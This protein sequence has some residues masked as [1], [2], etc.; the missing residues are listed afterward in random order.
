MRPSSSV[1]LV[2]EGNFSFAASLCDCVSS[3]TRIVATC[4]ESEEAA[5]R[6]ER[7]VGN[8][9]YLL[10]KGAEVYFLVDCTDLQGC[11][12]LRSRRFD[13]IIF[14][15]PHCGRK[16]GVKKNR[17][18]LAK[19]FVSCA[20]VLTARGEVRVTLC[21]GQGGT[22]A[23]QP[24]RSW[25]N[26]WQIV[27]MA[28]GANFILTGVHPFDSTCYDGYTSTG[29]RSQDKGFC[30]DGALAHVFTR[31][32]PV[33]RS[34]PVV[35]ETRIGDEH[36]YFQIPGE[37]ADKIN[38]NFLQ[39]GSTHP[40]NVIKDL[41]VKQISAEAAA[42]ELENDFPLLTKFDPGDR[43]PGSEIPESEIYFVGCSS[44]RAVRCGE[45]TG[46][47]CCWGD[48]GAASDG[49]P[50]SETPDAAR[51]PGLSEAY[52]LCPALTGYLPEVLR[53]PDFQAGVIYTLSGRVFRRCPISPRTMPAFHELLLVAA[54][55]P[56]GFF[57]RFTSAVEKAIT[58]LVESASGDG[59][60]PVALEEESGGGRWSIRVTAAAP[61][62]CASVAAGR[63]DLVPDPTRG[64]LGVCL[65]SVNLG[66]LTMA[67]C[68]ISDWR[69]LWTRDWCSPCHAGGLKLPRPLSG[70]SLYPP[71]YTHDVS[72]W[73]EPGAEPA[74]LELHAAARRVSGGSVKTMEL[75]DSFCH[76]GT[77]RRSYCYRLTYQSC[78]RALSYQR[79]LQ[80]QLDFRAELQSAFRVA[81]R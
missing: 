62:G 64:G 75:I 47:P 22:G 70:L 11:P 61:P 35:L 69:L 29:Y 18:L 12:S 14:N 60:A 24:A 59:P 57:R 79:A 53:R 55:S 3:D 76:P 28:A 23:D 49:S 73:V 56:L 80:M 68:R 81:L 46:P 45:P 44:H 43:W 8:I 78:D 5:T 4:Y 32:L 30:L 65:A 16:A 1:L 58:V 74:E 36:H 19:F 10:E 2:G 27:A 54:A 38:R 39:K 66:L 7:A 72:F 26:S 40:V 51:V 37:L 6:H 50:G 21:K 31:S 71:S 63:V 9:D 25:H 20:E 67:L 15:F 48:S 41:L 42:Q 34:K 77:N 52:C 13:K 17:E 33:A